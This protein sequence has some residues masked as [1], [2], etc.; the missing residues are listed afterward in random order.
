[1]LAVLLL[2]TLA[3]TALAYRFYGRFLER[4]TGVD[5]SNPTPAHTLNDGVDYVPTR[6]SVVFGHHFSSIAGAGPIV[7]PI[8][9]AAAFGWGPV[10]LWVIFG[11]IF[12]GGVHDF[13]STIMSLR[14][15]GKSIVAAARDLVG[16]R[17]GKLLLLF[18]L[19]TLI[20]VIIVFL[21]LTVV[22]F[23][24]TPAVA[25]AS[26][27][28]V[29]MALGFGLV[30]NRTRLP[31]WASVT[32]FVALTYAGLA[33]GHFFPAP[34]LGKDA[35]ITIVLI[36][37]FAAAILPVGWLMQPRDFLSATFLYAILAL[38]LVGALVARQDFQ[39]DFFTGF[40]GENLGLLVPFLFITVACGAC[41]GFHSMVASGTT[42]K[43]LNRETDVRRVAYGG[44][45]VEAVLATFALGCIAVVGGMKGSAIDT[46][47]NG[48]AV[49][50]GAL[51]VPQKLGVEFAALA[52][53]TFLL[54]TLDTCTRLARFLVE[55]LFDWH[56]LP[57]RLAATAAIVAVSGTLAAQK[58]TS[59]SGELVPA[60]K[61]LWPLFGAT[62]QLL[63]ALALVTITVF[64]RSRRIAIWFAALP[65]ALMIAMPLTAMIT[66]ALDA[67]MDA[68]LRVAAILQLALGLFVIAMGVR[69]LVR[70]QMTP[71]NA[72]G[73]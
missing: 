29:L 58:F 13:G 31:H 1:M 36:Y 16:E 35:W 33:V 45:L 55:E 59:L 28:F 12:I 73:A 44:M 52:V 11:A 43:Q 9:A 30:I 19:L 39:L 46:F 32:L 20:Y 63:A 47:A 34:D 65:A 25:T 48:A 62:N 17:T 8:I 2:A 67:R 3:L 18:V 37:C 5:D 56:G 14:Y 53:S 71:T 69:Y 4:Q 22:G 61:A 42:S 23:V 49:F 41:S 10:W 6:A 21:D 7:G 27:W 26:G 60:W 54:T 50:F 57:A 40:R 38:G 68:L 70:P 51:G 24:S 64:L 15:G 66:M 72:V